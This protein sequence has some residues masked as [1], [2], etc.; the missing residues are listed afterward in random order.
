MSKADD[1]FEKL[2]GEWIGEVGQLHRSIKALPEELGRSVHPAVKIMKETSGILER[3]LKDTPAAIERA[4]AATVE[5]MDE[6]T[7][8]TIGFATRTNTT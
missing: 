1:A 2:A 5:K 6:E 8:E 3:L 4:R 7:I